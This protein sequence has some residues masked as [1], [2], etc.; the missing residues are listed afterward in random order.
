M[1]DDKKKTLLFCWGKYAMEEKANFVFISPM[2]NND[3]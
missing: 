3:K 2:C 1:F